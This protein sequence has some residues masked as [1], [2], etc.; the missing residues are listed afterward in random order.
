MDNATTPRWPH[1]NDE[2]KDED[3]DTD[4][5]TI[6]THHKLSDPIP[7]EGLDDNDTEVSCVSRGGG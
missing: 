4:D 3:K 6:N 2:G 1:D 7:R 5:D